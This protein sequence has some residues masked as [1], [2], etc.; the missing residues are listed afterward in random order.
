MTKWR[1]GQPLGR[2]AS[3][4]QADS[5]PKHGPMRTCTIISI[6]YVSVLSVCMP[7]YDPVPTWRLLTFP[8]VVA[9]LDRNPVES[10]N[11]KIPFA[12]T[13]RHEPEL[14]PQYSLK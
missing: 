7:I 12:P 4:K 1:K 8:R 3:A 6:N 11:Q 13:G 5:N 2:G 14:H 9:D 10:C